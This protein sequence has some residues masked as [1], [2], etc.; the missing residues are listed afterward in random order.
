M[1][2][3]DDL[4]TGSRDFAHE[5]VGNC[6]GTA[7]QLPCGFPDSHTTGI[8]AFHLCKNEHDILVGVIFLIMWGFF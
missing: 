1:T 6:P 4:I 5:V 8:L 2:E 3:S 7:S